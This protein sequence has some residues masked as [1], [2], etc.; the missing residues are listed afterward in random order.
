MKVLVIDDSERL[1]RSLEHGLTRCGFVVE[2][3]ANGP[4]GLAFARHGSWDVIVLDLMLP[5]MDGLEVLRALRAGGD[6]THVLVLSAKDE[7]VE[8]VEGLALGADDYLVKPFDFDELVARLRALVRRKYGT[9]DPV[10]RAGGISLDSARRRVEV[11]GEPVHLTRNEYAILELLLTR[12]G[13][14]VSKRELLEHL[15][16]RDEGGSENSVEVFVHQLR[17]KV[18]ERGTDLIRTR[19]GHGYLVE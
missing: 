13:R 17:R 15:H 11:D 16:A 14:V 8:R 12:R 1:R 3:A 9:K 6:G 7:V 19:R 18:G 2:T 10:L 5:G 4:E